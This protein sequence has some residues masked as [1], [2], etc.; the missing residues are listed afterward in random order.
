MLFSALPAQA[1]ADARFIPVL[2]FHKVDDQPKYPEDISS[3]QLDSVFAY[4]W[5]HGYRPV[6]VSDILYGRVDYVVPR[7]R[8]PLCITAD[9]AHQSILF[10]TATARHPDLHN[11]RS[12]LEIFTASTK[13]A[14]CAPR[15]TFFLGGVGNNRFNDSVGPYF[16]GH[17]SL[18]AIVRGL[19]ATPGVELGYHTIVH[20][21][22]ADMSPE[23]AC[24]VVRDQM[25]QFRSM[26]V[27]EHISPVLAYPF[28]EPPVSAARE[29][30]RSLGII[31]AVTAAP[32]LREAN[33][34]TLKG[35]RYNGHL[36]SN[37]FLIPRVNIG[38]WT[39]TQ[40]VG[41]GESS[42]SIIDPTQDFVKD[43]CL[44]LRQYVSRGLV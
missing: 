9:D 29:A 39:Y 30:L 7:G 21:D 38:A 15:A 19:A 27:F 6:N 35:C 22:M 44:P 17:A 28:G 3:S 5:R 37:P 25:A 43:A 16:A 13:A 8:K 32:G 23:T 24:D 10:S 34:K 1:A 41:Y 36:H 11:A 4:A 33:E 40:R 31:G 20:R 26:G 18:R 42:Y 2:M 14:G 12:F